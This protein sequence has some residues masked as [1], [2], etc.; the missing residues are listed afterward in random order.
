MGRSQQRRNAELSMKAVTVQEFAVRIARRTGGESFA[1]SK[2]VGTCRYR[3]ECRAH[4]TG[5]RAG[6]NASTTR[7]AAGR[8]S[9]S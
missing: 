9:P 2:I 3:L 5:V 7:H 4:I 6:T 1:S 8:P